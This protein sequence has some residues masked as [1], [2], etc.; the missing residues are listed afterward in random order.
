MSEGSDQQGQEWIIPL[1][2]GT[3]MD[4]EEAYRWL[5]L[6]RAVKDTPAVHQ[7]SRA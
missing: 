3:V 2:P 6:S 5:V 4:D 7:H 1:I